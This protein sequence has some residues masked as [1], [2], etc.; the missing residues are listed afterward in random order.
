MNNERNNS[1]RASA[2]SS[3]K[4][5]IGLKHATSK[6]TQATDVTTTKILGLLEKNRSATG[7]KRKQCR[8]R[9]CDD[10]GKHVGLVLKCL[11]QG[12]VVQ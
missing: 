8:R 12:L 11:W 2:K 3:G 10:I 1:V 7:V 6:Q 5:P 4:V 9:N